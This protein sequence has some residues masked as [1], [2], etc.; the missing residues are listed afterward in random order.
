MTN[1]KLREW[2]DIESKYRTEPARVRI[3]YGLDG[4][5][6]INIYDMYND[7]AINLDKKAAIQL[8]EALIKFANEIKE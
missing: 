3:T 2:V 6:L 1:Y 8:A 4:T 5:E 7:E